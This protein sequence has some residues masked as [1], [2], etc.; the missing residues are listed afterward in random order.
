MKCLNFAID[1]NLFGNEENERKLIDLLNSILITQNLN[2]VVLNVLF[3]E[4]D[5][6]ALYRSIV[7]LEI[8]N[9]SAKPIGE[10]IRNVDEYH[11]ILTY[12]ENYYQR[13]DGITEV[14]IGKTNHDAPCRVHFTN[15]GFTSFEVFYYANWNTIDKIISVIK[16][17]YGQEGLISI[18]NDCDVDDRDALYLFIA[19]KHHA[20]ALE[21]IDVY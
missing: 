20:N 18:R 11:P 19:S 12:I 8:P 21:E 14:V 13:Y 6:E 17:A 9:L 5:V 15:E 7:G 3:R 1:R 2:G 4:Y 10:L 16:C